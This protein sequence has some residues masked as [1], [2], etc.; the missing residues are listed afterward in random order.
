MANDELE[1]RRRHI[2][3]ILENIPT[4]VL[5]LD[6]IMRVTHANAALTRLFRPE[7]NGNGNTSGIIRGAHLRDVFPQEVIDDLAHMLR[8]S[9]RMGS[10]T[11]QLEATIDGRN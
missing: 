6:A 2:E 9:D 10:T 1:Q 11:S 8:K 5:S 7:A 4:G 3:T